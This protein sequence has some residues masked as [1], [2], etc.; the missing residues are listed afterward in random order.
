MVAE[1]PLTS[2]SQMP[3]LPGLSF[4]SSYLTFLVNYNVMAGFY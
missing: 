3:T 2:P 4:L 1:K